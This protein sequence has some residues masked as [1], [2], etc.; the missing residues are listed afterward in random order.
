MIQKLKEDY[1]FE[2]VQED[3][4]ALH[5][6]IDSV[7]VLNSAGNLLQEDEEDSQKGFDL[8]VNSLYCVQWTNMKQTFKPTPIKQ[9]I[10]VK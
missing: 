6:N 1:F 9:H 8:I 7:T 10:E 4:N 3:L 5:W 2:F